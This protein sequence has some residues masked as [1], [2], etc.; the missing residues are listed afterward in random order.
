MLAVALSRPKP[1]PPP[2]PA[3]ETEKPLEGFLT[4]DAIK[5]F[6]VH[7][8][9]NPELIS[10]DNWNHD[11]GLMTRPHS[12]RI[13]LD[14]FYDYRT[15]VALYPKWQAFLREKQPKTLRWDCVVPPR[16]YGNCRV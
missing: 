4:R 9:A 3:P 15:N 7:G 12:V 2:A 6:Y 14:L 16:L 1:A 13:N 8:S 10:P 5:S 11:F